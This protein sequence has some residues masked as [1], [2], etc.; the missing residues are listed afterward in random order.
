MKRRLIFAC[1]VLALVVLAFG[2]WAVEAIRGA[3]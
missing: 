1:L 3:K 2:G